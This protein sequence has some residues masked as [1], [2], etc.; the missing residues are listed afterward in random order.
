MAFGTRKETHLAHNHTQVLRFTHPG[1]FII[2]DQAK[3]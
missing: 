2:N 1:T 3:M